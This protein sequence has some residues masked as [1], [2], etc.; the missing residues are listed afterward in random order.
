MAAYRFRVKLEWNPTSVWRDIV[1]GED[2]TL[3]EFQAIINE[4]MGLNQA[5][6]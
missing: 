5:H 3:T 1:V 2:R 6:L 4:S